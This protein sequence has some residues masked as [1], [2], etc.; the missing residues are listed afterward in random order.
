M[1][2]RISKYLILFLRINLFVF[3]A[4]IYLY[5][6][7]HLRD[8]IIDFSTFS[9]VSHPGVID[10]DYVQNISELS[11]VVS[12]QSRWLTNIFVTTLM[13]LCVSVLIYL[14]FLKI[15]YAFI[16]VCFYLI[17]V[18]FCIIF[19]SI[20]SALNSIDLGYHF[21][22]FIK[23]QLIHSPFVFILLVSCLKVFKV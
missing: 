13:I 15:R 20:G 7:Y 12:L 16:S 23:D 2:E 1:K 6:G 3:I 11:N 5:L 9:F 8:Y 17:L 10:T 19:I 18:I 22:R 21:A 4:F 14:I